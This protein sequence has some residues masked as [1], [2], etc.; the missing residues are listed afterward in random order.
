MT[1]TGLSWNLY[2]AHLLN[3]NGNFFFIFLRN[4]LCDVA[5]FCMKGV[6]PR[7]KHVLLSHR[8]L[9]TALTEIDNATENAED[10]HVS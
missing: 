4:T 8:Q 6:F 7:P 1:G 10:V 9:F 5:R 3:Y 2:K